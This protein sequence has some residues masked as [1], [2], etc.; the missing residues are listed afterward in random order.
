MTRYWLIFKLSWDSERRN[1]ERPAGSDITFRKRKKF[2][3]TI[4]GK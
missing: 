3:V 1:S 2:A 4:F